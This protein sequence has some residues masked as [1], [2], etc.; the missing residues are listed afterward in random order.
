ME[1]P[2]PLNIDP[3][4]DSIEK[5]LLMENI[6]ADYKVTAEEFNKLLL[7]I[8]YLYENITIPSQTVV[9]GCII[10][11]PDE[12]IEIGEAY[13][14][15]MPFNGEIIS[16][17]IAVKDAPTGNDILVHLKV[18]GETATTNP[19]KISISELNSLAPGNAPTFLASTPVSAGVMLTPN[20]TQVGSTNPG[21]EMIIHYLLLKI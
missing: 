5:L 20:I 13:A 2:F 9:W 11:P 12:N 18:N 16:Y 8:Q 10:T 17:W 1:N 15:P 6:P 14:I 21:K 3:K 4:Q 7:C 19:A